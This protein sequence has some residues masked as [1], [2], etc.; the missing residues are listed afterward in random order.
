MSD[1]KTRLLS[2]REVQRTCGLAKSTLYRFMRTGNFP[3]PLKIGP[4][5]VR[6]RSDEIQE[7]VESRAR[8]RGES[9]K[10]AKSNSA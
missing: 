7:W 5:A 6:W 1:I 2:R 3:E 4:K 10:A 8:A 9:P